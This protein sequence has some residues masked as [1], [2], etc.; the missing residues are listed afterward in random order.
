VSLSVSL[1][2]PLLLGCLGFIAP[3]LQAV[4]QAI[5][6]LHQQTQA[7]CELVQFSA[8]APQTVQ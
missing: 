3:N 5:P 2:M 1:F 7:Q 6:C 8:V 4:P